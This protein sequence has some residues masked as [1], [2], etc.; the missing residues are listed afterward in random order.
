MTFLHGGNVRAFARRFGLP[1]SEITDFSTSANP[2]GPPL[3][4][5]KTY[6]ESFGLVSRYPDPESSQLKKEVARQFPLW[7]ENVIA[8]NGATELIHLIVQLIRPRAALLLEPTFLEY[9]RALRIHGAEVR[10]VS[11]AEKHG[12]SAPLAH[13][14]HAAQ[15]VD[16]VF[17]ANPNNPT[18]VLR[19]RGE[20]ASFLEEMERRSV[21]TV[22]DE[23]F[24]DWMPEN[25]VGRLVTDR[26]SFFVIR[27]L[28]K[29]FNLPGLR[30]GFGLGAKRLVEKLE[31]LRVMWSVSGLA[32]A[33]GAAAL[34]DVEFQA[35]SRAWLPSERRF[36]EEELKPIEALEVFPSEANFI[37]ARLKNSM[38]VEALETELAESKI[39]VRNAANF[40][41]LDQ[42][43][44][45]VAVRD[46]SENVRLL[47]ALKKI[48]HPACV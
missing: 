15:G 40:I 24:I 47:E 9:R 12:F 20:V 23:A 41:G 33:L 38:G 26:S 8:G 31:R 28:T 7:P 36:L 16:M 37:L 1:E 35:R 11:L 19:E 17:L 10:P 21:F 43:Y 6:A 2:L 25:S 13:L 29:F 27:S 32:E 34:R 22:V 4:V 14:A 44:F 39:M 18:G 45:R 42:R 5:E 30:V 48:F 46:R 3:S